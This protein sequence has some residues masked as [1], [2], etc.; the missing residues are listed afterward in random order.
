MVSLLAAL[1]VFATVD[2]AAI[3]ALTHAATICNPQYE[4]GGVVRAVMRR[5][6]MRRPESTATPEAASEAPDPA[7]AGAG[8][9]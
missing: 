7:G 8:T 2:E 1:T 3:S 6:A 5:S 4:C 9:D